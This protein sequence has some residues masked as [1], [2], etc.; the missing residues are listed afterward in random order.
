LTVTRYLL[1]YAG[2]L[3]NLFMSVNSVGG[4]TTV[5]ISRAA[6]QLQSPSAASVAKAAQ[7]AAKVDS[8]TNVTGPKSAE[9]LAKAIQNAAAKAAT[10][11][12]EANPVY[13]KTQKP[14]QT[15]PVNTP[16]IDTFA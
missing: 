3:I 4:E 8:T 11:S 5:T 1:L 14:I 12:E 2:I 7:E 15:P 9:D 16:S 13:T 10:T 6:Q